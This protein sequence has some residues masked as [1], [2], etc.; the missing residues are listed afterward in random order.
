[1]LM[2]RYV[3]YTSSPALGDIRRMGEGD[4]IAL[5][6]ATRERKDWGRIVDALS[7]AV[8]RGAGVRWL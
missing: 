3:S 5:T 7:A 1:M 8:S 4:T 6:D 2:E